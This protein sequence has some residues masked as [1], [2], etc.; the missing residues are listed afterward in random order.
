MPPQAEAAAKEAKKKSGDS[1]CKDPEGK[2]PP[3]EKSKDPYKVDRGQMTFD[4]EGE[5]GGFY[6]SRHAHWP[7]T[8]ASGVTIGRGYDM[9]N[10][11]A[12]SIVSDMTKAGVPAN[13]AKQYS[14][15]AGL[16]GSA[17]NTWVKNNR[18]KVAELTPDQQKSL[19]EN[20]YGDMEKD[21][22]RISAKEDTV[23]AYGAVCWDKLDPK[24]KE[25]LIDLRFRGDYHTTSRKFLQKAVA[26][27]DVEAFKKEYTNAQN[28][29][30]VPP[31]R[32]KARQD[33][34]K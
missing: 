30:S 6:H 31:A 13:V 17:A 1:D 19:F 32:L 18:S 7:E 16:K 5:E 26:D 27:N 25:S 23:K 24:I 14:G 12:G 9:G 20:M 3:K 22:Q 21:I 29:A 28:W 8:A 4:S 11:S 33:Y 2:C 34:W 10:R 15:A